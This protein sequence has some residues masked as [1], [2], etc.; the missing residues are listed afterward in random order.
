M[1]TARRADAVSFFAAVPAAAAHHDSRAA[2]NEAEQTLGAGVG[3][4]TAA[5]ADIQ[6]DDRKMVNH[7]DRP[8]RTGAGAVAKTHAAELAIGRTGKGQACGGAAAVADII[9]FFVM[10]SQASGAMDHGYSPFDGPQLLAG[11]FSDGFGDLRLPGKTERRRNVRIGDHRF[12]IG[13]APGEPAGASLPAGQHRLH[14]L[15]LGVDFYREFVRGQAE[16]DAEKNADAPQQ[17]QAAQCQVN[18]S[19]IH[20]FLASEKNDVPR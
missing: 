11:D 3:A 9:V 1:Q 15:D 8:E 18:V 16:P 10:A 17:G 4:N 5:G 19:R 6:V 2:G 14:R 20:G 12:R 13:F 7:R